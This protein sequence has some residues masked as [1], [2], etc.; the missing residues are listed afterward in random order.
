M[1]PALLTPCQHRQSRGYCIIIKFQASFETHTML[2]SF[3]I[4][5]SLVAQMVRAETKD[6]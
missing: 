6:M 3:A 5:R 2:Y 1:T 4:V